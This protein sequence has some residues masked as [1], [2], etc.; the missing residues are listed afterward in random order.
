MRNAVWKERIALGRVGIH[1]RIERV[2]GELCK[3]FNV[4][5]RDFAGF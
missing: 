3:M 5:K 2:A 1:M 4:G